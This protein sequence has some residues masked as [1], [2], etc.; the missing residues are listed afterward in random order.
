MVI[1]RN[2][3][4]NTTQGNL[5]ELVGSSV[6]PVWCKLPALLRGVH[7]FFSTIICASNEENALLAGVFDEYYDNR[8]TLRWNWHGQSLGKVDSIF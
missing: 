4:K 8:Q 3:D 2:K 6:A 1:Y 7:A 5:A